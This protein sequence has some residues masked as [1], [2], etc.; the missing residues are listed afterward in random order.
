MEFERICNSVAQ[1][2]STSD[3]IEIVPRNPISLSA[4][5]RSAENST[6]ESLRKELNEFAGVTLHAEM[7]RRNPSI[8]GSQTATYR[9]PFEIH[10]RDLLQ[11]ICKMRA[12]F[13]QNLRDALPVL[14]GG[15][16]G[17]K[18]K[19]QN[20]EELHNLPVGQM[21]NYQ[22]YLAGMPK[23]LKEIDVLPYRAHAFG[24]PFKVDKRMLVDEADIDILVAQGGASTSSAGSATSGSRAGGGGRRVQQQE[25]GQRGMHHN[26]H[27]RKRKA[28]PLPRDFKYRRRSS[29]SES[30]SESGSSAPASPASS[31]ETSSI[32]SDDE[33]SSIASEGEILL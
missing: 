18:L 10:R 33:L 27:M 25:G 21:G 29:V 7:T 23:P 14:E 1:P 22:D 15:L 11:Q 26:P 9:N 2:L 30:G 8:P 19:L 31:E 24:N 12:N 5:L 3:R 13:M 4:I 17:T 6:L 32:I 28:G 16:P 20:A